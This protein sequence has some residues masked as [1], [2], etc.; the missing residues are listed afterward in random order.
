MANYNCD[1]SV[2]SRGNGSSAIASAAYNAGTHLVNLVTGRVSDYRRKSGIMNSFIIL[3]DEA[4]DWAANRN[5]LWNAVE[6][7]D[8]R[9]NSTLARQAL[10]SLPIELDE[11][12][13]EALAELFAIWICERFDVAVDVALHEP[14]REG[15]QRNFHVHIQ[16]T[17]RVLAADGLG[18]KTRELD[19]KKTGGA[20][21]KEI[22]KRWEVLVNQA[23][24]AAEKEARVDCR[25]LADKFTDMIK[26]AEALERRADEIEAGWFRISTISRKKKE[27]EQAAIEELRGRA[28]ALRIEAEAYNR[29]PNEHLGPARTALRR[30]EAADANAKA[31]A[32]REEQRQARSHE[33]HLSRLQTKREVHAARRRVAA[34]D[35]ENLHEFFY[36]RL[37]PDL[38]GKAFLDAL[39]DH[40]LVGAM[41]KWI[42]L[43]SAIDRKNL[44]E[45]IIARIMK[46]AADAR[47]A[48][49]KMLNGPVEH[50]VTD[51][52][53]AAYKA[54]EQ[55]ALEGAERLVQKEVEQA[56][57]KEGGKKPP[58]PGKGWEPPGM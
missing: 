38:G 9:V 49:I 17:T 48:V 4:P 36:D 13:R 7:K 56:A 44:V 40:K 1:I 31:E 19:S 25:S 18:A 2:V 50:V 12:A 28:A 15:D 24:E 30:K 45:K 3:P 21:I 53:L 6:Q 58:K 16:F 5:E 33:E 29:K 34:G 26:E 57:K 32:K 55:A 39:Q 10:V 42:D 54:Q 14:S 35:W 37:N 47:I 8:A 22:R 11:T 46:W 27:Q 20:V 41:E 52:E 43:E 51:E 23:L